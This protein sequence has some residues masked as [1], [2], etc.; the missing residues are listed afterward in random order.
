MS[1]P[2]PPTSTQKTIRSGRNADFAILRRLNQ[3][4]KTS[5]SRI[6]FCNDAIISKQ[7][8]EM[9]RSRIEGL[10][11]SFPKL[12]GNSDQHTFV[13]T[14]SVRYVYQPLEELY[15]VLLTNKQSNILQ[16]IDTL[17]LFARVVAEY[18][19]SVDE[20]EIARQSFELLNIFEEIVAMGYRES[21]TLAQIRTITEMES[22]DE[23]IQAEIEKNKEKEAKDE[24]NR[25][26]KMLEMQKR[27]MAKK[28]Y[29]GGSSSGFG[30][31]SGYGGGAGSYGGGVPGGFRGGPGSGGPG[32]YGG[33]SY[34]E[35]VTQSY[36]E[37]SYSA[38]SAPSSRPSGGKGMQLGRKQK[39]DALVEAIKTEEGIVDEGPAVTSSI[40]GTPP[41]AAPVHHESVHIV[42]EEKVSVKVS[43]DGG[44]ENMEVKGTM[45]LRV[46]DPSKAQLRIALRPLDTSQL[47]FNTHPNVDKNQFASG[48]IG[49]KDPSKSFPT[50]QSLPVLRWRFVTKDDNAMPLSINCWPSPSGNG[51]CD[52]NLEYELQTDVD[53]RDVVISIPYPGNS[54]PSVGDVEGHYKV[55]KNR[56]I[57]DWQLPIIDQS[58]K[59]GVLEFTVNSEDVSAFFPISVS[60]NSN[61]SLCHVD[62]AAIQSVAGQA[63]A[64]SQETVV[65]PD[66]Y[67]I[68]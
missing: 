35:P 29:S 18:C 39:T 57:I 44:L 23:R 48:I 26:A 20:R 52:V 37:P 33:P 7:F 58:N 31:G 34:N 64:F 60:F 28:G 22:H 68:V 61:K 25:K 9:P 54:A 21:V 51:T 14:E 66:E 55:D 47:Q 63:I 41:H 15:M 3:R 11:A 65:T 32:S 27:E 53:L 67:V 45:Q 16:D 38:S 5:T 2:S 62:A 56:R 19:R 4:E 8:I 13:E 24:L 6:C 43:R 40:A 50:G 1:S 12:I 59:N 42:I 30:G 49:L 17:H 36:S 46:S 10:L